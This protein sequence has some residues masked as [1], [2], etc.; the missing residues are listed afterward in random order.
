MTQ[1]ELTGFYKRENCIQV[2]TKTHN[3]FRMTTAYGDKGTG[4]LFKKS[5]HVFSCVEMHE[6][7]EVIEGGAG[8]MIIF[9]V[10]FPHSKM[11]LFCPTELIL[12]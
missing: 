12:L 2:S 11:L 1:Q 8:A 9:S 3:H 4:T 10:P 7:C 5:L 6:Q